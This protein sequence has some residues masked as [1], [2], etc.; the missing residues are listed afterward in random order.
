MR[1][2][3]RS[4]DMLCIKKCRCA[5]VSGSNEKNQ[6]GLAQKRGKDYNGVHNRIILR[7]RVQF[8]TGGKVRDP[9]RRAFGSLTARLIR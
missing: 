4:H 1:A 5:G 7:G 9:W 6:S 3:L 8:P 2:D